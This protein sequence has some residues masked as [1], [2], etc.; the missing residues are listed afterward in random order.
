M[1]SVVHFS[2]ECSGIQRHR[3]LWKYAIFLLVWQWLEEVL[4]ESRCGHTHTHSYLMCS[5]PRKIPLFSSLL[6][7][8]TI[9][10]LIGVWL[11]RCFSQP[12]YPC[13]PCWLTG[14]IPSVSSTLLCCVRFAEV[15]F[16]RRKNGSIY[17][18]ALEFALRYNSWSLHLLTLLY[19]WNNPKP[20]FRSIISFNWFNCKGSSRT[21]IWFF[22]FSHITV[23]GRW[24]SW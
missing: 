13:S 9:K 16:R 11:P 17:Q 1:K 5:C 4:L 12:G 14:C 24:I 22:F 8:S 21:E 6:K 15:H 18:K 3:L 10:Y 7:T 20:I 19:V 2:I 23:L